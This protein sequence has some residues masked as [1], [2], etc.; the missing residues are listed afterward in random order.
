M[1]TRNGA[2]IK[3]FSKE[4]LTK[5]ATP[6]NNASPP[7][8]AKS[9]T[10]KKFSQLRDGA[11]GWVGRAAEAG[12]GIGATVL[13]IAR[14]RGSNGM[15]GGGGELVSKTTGASSSGCMGR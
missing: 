7:T 13:G 6:K 14:G 9:F 8:Q 5:K 15:I 10:P 12:S 3:L 2:L 1:A 4:Y 11:N